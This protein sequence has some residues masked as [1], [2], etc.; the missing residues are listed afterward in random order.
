MPRFR[1][2]PIATDADLG[3]AHVL[4]DGCD[5]RRP[6]DEQAAADG[7]MVC[8][9]GR[10]EVR[11]AGGRVVVHPGQAVVL[12]GGAHYRVRHPERAPDACLSI[13]GAAAMALPIA[14]DGHVPI[15]P[16]AYARLRA[17]RRVGEPVER[18]ALDE[19][20]A[21]IEPAR[22]ASGSVADR[23]IAASIDHA[24]AMAPAAPHRLAELARGCG[25]SATHAA[26]AYRRATGTTIHQAHLEL[27]LR[28]AHALLLDTS[29]TLVA[30]AA[31]AGFADQA[32]LTRRFRRRFGVTPGR[33][34][35]GTSRQPGAVA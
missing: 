1:I 5:P 32:H 9:H 23:R 26:H 30:I 10:F 25:V 6:I 21:T 8:L 27:R 24:L 33:L 13:T 18:L 20:L 2:A 35:A 17:L 19:A 22:A 31:A 29:A 12:P 28:H 7:V 34:R 16:R 14:R 3:C 4:C 15:S 11:H